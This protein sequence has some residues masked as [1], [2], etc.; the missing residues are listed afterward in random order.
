MSAEEVLGVSPGDLYLDPGKGRQALSHALS[1][2]SA[3]LRPEGDPP[4]EGRDPQQLLQSL[5]EGLKAAAHRIEERHREAE[6]RRDPPP[7]A[8]DRLRR[9]GFFRELRHGDPDGPSLAQV[10]R[11]QP[12]P[13]EPE[14]VAYLRAAP[15]LIAAPG[16]IRDVFDPEGDYIGTPSVHSDGLWC[17]P[18][19]LATYVERYHLALPAAFLEHLV[20]R[21]WAIGQPDLSQARF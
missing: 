15:V 8:T 14:I 4:P 19:D 21:G 9:V 16:P 11:D 7:A 18:G 13:H 17:W 6:A 12:Q 20:A 10:R 3:R 2:A 1:W 5:G